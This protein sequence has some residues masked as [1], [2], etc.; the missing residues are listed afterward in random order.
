V[1]L[2]NAF[3]GLIVAGL[4]LTPTVAADAVPTAAPAAIVDCTSTPA[5]TVPDAGFAGLVDPG[6][7]NPKVGDPFATPATASIPDVYGYGGY[8]WVNYDLGCGPD[9]I[10]DTFNSGMGFFANAI[11]SINVSVSAISARFQRELYSTRTWQIL[12]PIQDRIARVLGGHVGVPLIMLFGSI[13]GIFVIIRARRGEVGWA[14]ARGMWVGICVCLITACTMAP[15]VLNLT[16]DRVAGG[17]IAYI[18]S[19]VSGSPDDNIADA[20]AANTQQ[21]TLYTTW[22]A[23]M[24]GKPD[25]DAARKFCP[26]LLAA[27][28]FTREEAEAIRADKTGATLEQLTQEHGKKYQAVAAELKTYCG[29]CYSYLAGKHNA[30]RALYALLGVYGT[31][32]ANSFGSVGAFFLGLLLAGFRLAIMLMPLIAL[33][34]MLERGQHLLLALADKVWTLGGLAIASGGFAAVFTAIIG[35][36]LDPASGVNVFVGY[37]ALSIANFAGWFL[38]GYLLWKWVKRNTHLQDR[39]RDWTN[40]DRPGNQAIDPGQSSPYWGGRQAPERTGAAPSEARILP[41]AINGA[42]SGAATTAVLGLATGGTATVAGIAAGA[43]KGALTAGAATTA[44]KVTGSETLGAVTATAVGAKTAAI[45]STPAPVAETPAPATPLSLPAG[46]SM[47]GRT[48][49]TTGVKGTNRPQSVH[50]EGHEPVTVD[51]VTIWRPS[52]KGDQA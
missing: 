39:L 19:A 45:G 17:S 4:V 47:A 3:A 12:D 1:K 36:V 16:L 41:A 44:T 31:G 50:Q 46:E 9:S 24:V 49:R 52:K 5:I 23:G 34:A 2:L 21:A 6:P 25:S 48:T 13:A 35:G 8:Q 40:R 7:T 43:G 33:P 15:T 38:L 10:R 51:G 20:L 30:D 27:A 28:T 37:I 18:N 14:G 32:M 26:Q 29:G 42:I 11:L 22:C